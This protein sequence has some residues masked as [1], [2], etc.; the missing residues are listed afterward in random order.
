[1]NKLQI[2]HKEL[3]KEEEYDSKEWR[4]KQCEQKHKWMK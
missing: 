2:Q 3:G 4:Q 1:M